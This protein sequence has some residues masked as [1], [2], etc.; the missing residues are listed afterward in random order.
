MKMKKKFASFFIQINWID[1]DFFLRK[2]SMILFYWFTGM[3]SWNKMNTLRIVYCT[4]TFWHFQLCCYEFDTIQ[5][6][7]MY[8][9]ECNSVILLMMQLYWPNAGIEWLQ[10]NEMKWN[11]INWIRLYEWVNTSLN[12]KS[13][14]NSYCPFWT[15]T[16][17]LLK[18]LKLGLKRVKFKAPMMILRKS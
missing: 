13:N 15:S 11:E 5:L 16:E 7:D 18:L 17:L 4:S 3:P 12:P 10:W 8:K 9:M 6:N 1:F 14:I 2:Q